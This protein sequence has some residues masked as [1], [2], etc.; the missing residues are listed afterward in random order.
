MNF[1]PDWGYWPDVHQLG[2]LLILKAGITE[3]RKLKLI[4]V[5]PKLRIKSKNSADHEKRVSKLKRK[6][7]SLMKICIKL[8]KICA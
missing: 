7:K 3:I 5:L 1:P 4:Q 2:Q 8:S 6:N